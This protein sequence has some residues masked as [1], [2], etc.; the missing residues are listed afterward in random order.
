MWGEWSGR[1]RVQEVEV[2]HSHDVICHCEE[3]GTSVLSEVDTGDCVT[4]RVVRDN[5]IYV[6]VMEEL[7]LGDTTIIETSDELVG[8][9]D[10]GMISE[11]FDAL[12]CEPALGQPVA[13]QLILGL[14]AAPILGSARG[15]SPLAVL[16]L[17][18]DSQ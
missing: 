2:V 4:P 9:A 18:W 17:E 13:S 1:V 16:E 12:W 3:T 11:C 6:L 8:M 7:P 14:P 15:S 10:R 5:P